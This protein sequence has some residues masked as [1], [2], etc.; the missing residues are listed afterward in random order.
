MLRIVTDGAADMPSD[1][2]EK[3]EINVIPLRIRFGEENYT[4]GV[5]ID[6]KS[7]YQIVS[8]KHQI[9]NTSLPSPHQVVEFYRAI[10]EKGDEILSIHIASKLSGTFSI[11]EMAAREA[12]SEF[13]VYPFD[14]TAGS[15]I[16]GF[17]CREAR[18]LA[19]QGVPINDILHRLED[20]RQ[21]ITVIFTLD[22]LEYAQMNGRVNA[23]Q[24]AIVSMLRVKPIIVLR[25]GL[26]SMAE[27]VR[28]RQK[29]IERTIEYVRERIG[30]QPVVMAIVH[31]N[32]LETA[33]GLMEKVKGI[34]NIQELLIT[35]LAIPVAANLGPG[36]IGIAA[37][38]TK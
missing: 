17:M 29:S 1:W 20:I 27:K 14:S 37:Y 6:N 23:L 16:Q 31:A 10:A 32:D 4:Q 7:F 21:K 35:D 11:I 2:P 30:D 13:K 9:P 12:A 33:C 5:D 38:I 3:Y 24:S 15:A 34:F 8:Q 36:T 28:T 22:S 18:L 26:L 25:D 19:R